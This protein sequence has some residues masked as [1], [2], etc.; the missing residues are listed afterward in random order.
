MPRLVVASVH[1]SAALLSVVFVAV[2]LLTLFFDPYAQLRLADLVLPF[3]AEYRPLWTGL[4]TLAADLLLAVVVTSLLRYRIGLRG[5]RAVHRLAHA[6]WPVAWL[7]A[8]G[9]G[10]DA[11]TW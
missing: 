2:H 1:R 4:G 8:L 7:H 6:C 11:G 5:W 10:T 9:T 3:A